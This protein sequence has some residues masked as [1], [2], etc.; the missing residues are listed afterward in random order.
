MF[1]CM[2]CGAVFESGRPM[3]ESHGEVLYHCPNCLGLEICD[4]SDIMCEACEEETVDNSGDKW[5]SNCKLI[6]K[7]AMHDVIIS[8]MRRQNLSVTTIISAIEDIMEG[9]KIDNSPYSLIADELAMG[10][11]D[12]AYRCGCDFFTAQDMAEAWAAGTL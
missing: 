2:E 11:V 8:C 6:T 3:Q 10:T 9:Q 4:V 7:Q 12:I 5:C 1:K